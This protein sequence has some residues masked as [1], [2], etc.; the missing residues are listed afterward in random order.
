MCM[1]T[2]WSGEHCELSLSRG[3]STP[4]VNAVAH[5]AVLALQGTACRLLF[6]EAEFGR[7]GLGII[8]SVEKRDTFNEIVALLF[9]KL[10]TDSSYPLHLSYR[11][12]IGYP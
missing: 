6:R 10:P 11:R 2:V 1:T 7:S 5:S 3:A 12:T 4:Q 9:C 8:W